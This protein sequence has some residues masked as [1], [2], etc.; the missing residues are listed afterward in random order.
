M[1]KQR[2]EVIPLKGEELQKIVAEV[3]SIPP[4]I[5]DKVKAIYPLN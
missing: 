3:G 1:N 5:L 2:L 4:A